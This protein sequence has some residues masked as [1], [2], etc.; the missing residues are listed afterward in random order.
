MGVPSTEY[1]ATDAISVIG[2]HMYHRDEKIFINKFL[3][4][5]HTKEQISIHLGLCR[6]INYDTAV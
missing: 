5:V 6:L 1:S 4:K 3:N 2:N